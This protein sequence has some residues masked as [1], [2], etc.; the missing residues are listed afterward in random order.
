MYK[1]FAVFFVLLILGGAGCAQSSLSGNGGL[2]EPVAVPVVEQ[3]TYVGTWE[4]QGTYVDGV[5][6]NDYPATLEM[7]VDSFYSHNDICETRGALEV[8]G[9]TITMA[10]DLSQT[11]CQV[12]PGYESITYTQSFNEDNTKMTIVTV[13]LGVE[14][15]EE[16]V[17]SNQ[18]IEE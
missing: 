11:T 2:P 6:N 14:V 3:P 15:M 10:M 13:V 7:Q 9:D 12:V 4:R 5:L 17:R 16:Y 8:E 18:E 1:F